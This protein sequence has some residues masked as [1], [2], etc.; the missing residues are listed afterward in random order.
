MYEALPRIARGCDGDIADELLKILRRGGIEIPPV[1]HRTE[2]RGREAAVSGRHR[3]P[4]E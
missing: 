1:L 2:P 3:H 4:A